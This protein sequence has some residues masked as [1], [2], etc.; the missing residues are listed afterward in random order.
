MS[1][2]FAHNTNLSLILLPPESLETQLSASH[3]WIFFPPHW[4]ACAE[5][6]QISTQIKGWGI[7]TPADSLVKS[8]KWNLR[9]LYGC[10]RRWV[11]SAPNTHFPCKS[12]VN[13]SSSMICHYPIIDWLFV[14]DSSKSIW[15]PSSAVVRKCLS[16]PCNSLCQLHTERPIFSCFATVG[17]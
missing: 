6:Y 13:C 4:P 1:C 17:F 12:L 15:K 8:C 2:T 7:Q 9:V 11:Q 5:E 16:S 10:Y 3:Q 14:Q